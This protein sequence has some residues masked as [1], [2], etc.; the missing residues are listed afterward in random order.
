MVEF[1]VIIL[2]IH[3]S[4]IQVRKQEIMF[5]LIEIQTSIFFLH[6]YL[7]FHYEFY[8]FEVETTFHQMINFNL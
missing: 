6:S 8:L 3:F 7:L 1:R 2:S 4:T 5:F